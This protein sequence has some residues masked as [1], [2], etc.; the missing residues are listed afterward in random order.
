MNNIEGRNYERILKLITDKDFILPDINS[1]YKVRTLWNRI[2]EL[3]I[4]LEKYLAMKEFLEDKGAVKIHLLKQLRKR[5][6]NDLFVSGLNKNIDDLE[7]M[8]IEP[9]TPFL[10][11]SLYS[12]AA[13]FTAQQNNMDQ[14]KRYRELYEINFLSYVIMILIINNFDALV[15]EMKGAKIN[16]EL[17]QLVI[18]SAE[19]KKIIEL[20]SGKDKKIGIQLLMLHR[21]T[22][23]FNKSGNDCLN[24]AKDI[25]YNNIK[26]NS[27]NLNFL[28]FK[29][30]LNYCIKK[31][32]TDP[33][34]HEDTIV[35][36]FEKKITFG[37][38]KDLMDPT[39]SFNHFR[40]FVLF[41]GR[42]KL[43]LLD[44]YMKK[45]FPHVQPALKSEIEYF[46]KAIRSFY[47]DDF[48]KSLNFL[49]KINKKH[50]IHYL[51]YFKFS[52]MVYY[53]TSMFEELSQGLVN[54]KTY[55]RRH[56]EY[57]E[58]AK[59]KIFNF[60]DCVN[61]LS[62]YKINRKMKFSDLE[63]QINKKAPVLEP[64]WLLKQ[65]FKLRKFHIHIY[66]K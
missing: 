53:E 29:F 33:G 1:D 41:A 10:K 63:F 17:S 44:L 62:D 26:N 13:F 9:Q 25:F 58:N 37:C 46:I 32:E 55:V 27:E 36:L 45:V 39:P 65:L 40:D 66:K 42:N 43:S 50:Y 11:Q 64:K 7:N 38:Y 30:M 23:T 61:L 52:S 47:T 18:N 59:S 24:E 15:N 35:E 8:L 48:E 2:S 49:K 34:K 56:N 60:I 16:S 4:L 31:E 14:Y 19:I 5:N 20:I 51:D 54:F 57:S 28:L 22:L 21:L 6:L 12:E 3:T